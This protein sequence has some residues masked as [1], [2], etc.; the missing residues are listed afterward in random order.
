MVGFVHSCIPAAPHHP[1]IV[2]LRCA[3]GRPERL[4]L[5]SYVTIWSYI[6]SRL[7]LDQLKRPV[8]APVSSAPDVTVLLQ[9]LS[10]GRLE[11]MDQLLPLVYDELKVLARRRLA[12]EYSDSTLA[13]TGL[14]HEAYLKLV[15]NPDKVGW[16]DRAHFFAVAS[17]AMRQVLVTRAIARK[18]QK[19]G[20]DAEHVSLDDAIPMTEARADELI[21]LG[22][23]LGKLQE[24]HTRM[25]QIVDLRYFGGFTIAECAE[26]LDVS[27]ATVNR[28]WRVARLWLYDFIS[29]DHE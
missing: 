1:R 17:R 8:P 28:D 7:T 4:I 20:G 18:A 22:E 13:T 9:Q 5:A 14:V 21:A 29:S 26:I 6:P 10:D 25:S 27:E 23:A 16:Q 12:R 2:A 11:A 19:R 24:T 15:R 3:A